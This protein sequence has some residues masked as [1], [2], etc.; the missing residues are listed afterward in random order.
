MKM[1]KFLTN[2]KDNSIQHYIN[3]AKD[4]INLNLLP[5]IQN[6]NELLELK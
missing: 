1:N 6:S 2:L 5:I 3:L 4:Y